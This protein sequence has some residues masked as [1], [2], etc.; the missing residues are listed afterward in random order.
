MHGAATPWVLR[1]HRY[2]FPR[3]YFRCLPWWTVGH[4]VTS[5]VLTPPCPVTTG[6]CRLPP[7][8]TRYYRMSRSPSSLRNSEDP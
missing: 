7:G 6:C 1:Q 2:C 3:M 5:R 4:G 8:T